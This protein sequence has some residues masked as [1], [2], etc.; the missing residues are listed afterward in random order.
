MAASLA[1]LALPCG[2]HKQNETLNVRNVFAVLLTFLVKLGVS[3]DQR[4]T[5]STAFNPCNVSRTMMRVSTS[6][7]R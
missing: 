6:D 4:N 1:A 7:G 5:A 2:G 3:C